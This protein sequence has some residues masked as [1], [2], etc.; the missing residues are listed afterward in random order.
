MTEFEE[1][2]L[3]LLSDI[4]TE[5]SNVKSAVNVGVAGALVEDIKPAIQQRCVTDVYG[6]E[7]ELCNIKDELRDLNNNM[8][9]L[10]NEIKK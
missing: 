10:I 4:K 5:I 1:N 9:E 8:K 2:Q 6:L 3:Y 7:C